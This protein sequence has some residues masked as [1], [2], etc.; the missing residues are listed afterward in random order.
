MLLLLLPATAA[1]DNV[2]TRARFRQEAEERKYN[3][4]TAKLYFDKPSKSD[5]VTDHKQ[6]ATFA[7]RDVSVVDCRYARSREHLLA[8]RDN[9]I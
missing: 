1:A 6:M 9:F 3:Y 8:G 4:C 2:M 7:E 5:D